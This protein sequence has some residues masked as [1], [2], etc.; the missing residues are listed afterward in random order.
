MKKEVVSII[1]KSA[2]IAGV[3]CLAAG[4]VAVATSG[5]A[6]KAIAE[7]GKYL[8]KTV[9]E[10]W[11]EHPEKEAVVDAEMVP[12]SETESPASEE[13]IQQTV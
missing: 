5:A 3:T 13:T 7:S 9:K 6:L 10:I 1:Q 8:A 2:K 12:V 11:G 4:V